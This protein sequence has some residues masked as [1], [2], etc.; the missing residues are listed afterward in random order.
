MLG[1]SHTLLLITRQVLARIDLAGKR[2]L[3][4]Q[5][6][7][8]QPSRDYES[9]AAE[10]ARAI[11]L[12]PRRPGRVTV[13]CPD[14][15]TDVISVPAD[16][17]AIATEQEILT[18]LALEAEVDSGLSAFDSRIGAM[19]LATDSRDDSPWCVTQVANAQWRELSS[20][21]RGAGSRL[22]G[23]AHPLAANLGALESKSTD[24]TH[25]WIRQWRE[26][27]EADSET[28]AELA[29]EWAAC[30]L[31]KPRCPLL[32]I[33]DL[34]V[35][36]TAQPLA[37]SALLAIL[38]ACG[39]G[40]WNWQTQRGLLATA[41]AIA[42][43]EKKSSQQD[44]ADGALKAVETSLLQLRQEVEKAQA[45]RQSTERQLQL[46]GATHTQQNLRWMAL[47]D[48][49]AQSASEECWIQK[50]ESTA[51]QTKVHGLA[52]NNAAANSFAGRLEMALRD[53][54]WKTAPAATGFSQHNLVAFS[55]VLTAKLSPAESDVNSQVT[56]N[57]SA[58]SHQ[59]S[60]A[61]ARLRRLQP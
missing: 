16:V 60:L 25:A 31:L 53:S 43:L 58:S 22:H 29:S 61:A 21:V 55:I 3:G 48:G 27:A 36:S 52:L 19:R 32:L 11:K 57:M 33:G 47:V 18:A 35:P 26:P 13:L 41:Q 46:A 44:A 4:V 45:L 6:I 42:G 54:G 23:V 28:L 38:A 15:W 34:Q 40:F 9:L 20:L 2:R 39:C 50:L 49:L 17:A 1:P 30:L 56:L 59:A 14:F 37:L 10:V 12:G 8:T 24:Q 7:W 5:Q 51:V